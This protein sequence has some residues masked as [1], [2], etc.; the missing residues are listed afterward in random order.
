[1][2]NYFQRNPARMKEFLQA[3]YEAVGG[4]SQQVRTLYLYAKTVPEFNKVYTSC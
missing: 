1:M 4:E 2:K 3:N